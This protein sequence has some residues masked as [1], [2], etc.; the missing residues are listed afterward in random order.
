MFMKRAHHSR[1]RPVGPGWDINN[2]GIVDGRDSDQIAALAVSLSAA[3]GA[4]R[5]GRENLR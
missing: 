5:D 1:L 2:D 3:A 4:I